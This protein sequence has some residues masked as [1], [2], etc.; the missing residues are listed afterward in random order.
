MNAENE[1]KLEKIKEVLELA[2]RHG[3]GVNV[4]MT[5]HTTQSTDIIEEAKKVL[6]K[7]KLRKKLFKSSGIKWIKF[8]NSSKGNYLYADLELSI[9]YP[10]NGGK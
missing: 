6:K 7:Y 4:D 3:K 2:E 10:R 5:I 1:N 8:H 9:F